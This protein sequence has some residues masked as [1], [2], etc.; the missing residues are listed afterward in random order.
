MG[1]IN[2]GPNLHFQLNNRNV[3][4]TFVEFANLFELDTLPPT[5]WHEDYKGDYIYLALSGKPCPN[6]QY[7]SALP[8]HHP[9]PKIFQGFSRT[10]LLARHELHNTQTNELAILVHYFDG[11]GILNI[12]RYIITH[13]SR[14]TNTCSNNVKTPIHCGGLITR[15]AIKIRGFHES[16]YERLTNCGGDTLMNLSYF[17]F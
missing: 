15:I 5:Q 7:T 12:A 10:C 11:Y 13:L 9:V 8:F 3:N 1:S 17:Q 14:H 16:R 6:S 2:S 4:L